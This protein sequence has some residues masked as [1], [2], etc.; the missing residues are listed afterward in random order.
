MVIYRQIIRGKHK[1]P[2]FFLIAD[3]Y[4]ELLAM[5][6]L[7]LLVCSRVRGKNTVLKK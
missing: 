6:E 2:Y 4:D 3:F 7:F 1:E 5:S